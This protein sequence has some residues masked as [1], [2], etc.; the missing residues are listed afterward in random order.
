MCA[1]RGGPPPPPPLATP[2]HSYNTILYKQL[3]LTFASTQKTKANILQVKSKLRHHKLKARSSCSLKILF[4]NEFI[5]SIFFESKPLQLCIKFY[6][7][8]VKT[9]LN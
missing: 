8:G 7:S 6:V 2:L 5:Y 4:S 3:W 1:A 9:S